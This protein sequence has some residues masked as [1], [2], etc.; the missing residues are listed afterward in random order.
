MWNLENIKRLARNEEV[1]AFFIDLKIRKKIIGIFRA[2]FKN[3]KNK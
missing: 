3:K 1:N 2:D